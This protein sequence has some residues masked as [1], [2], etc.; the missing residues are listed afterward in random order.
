MTPRTE[1]HQSPKISDQLAIYNNDNDYLFETFIVVNILP[2]CNEKW[3][4]R[5]VPVHFVSNS[6]IVAPGPLKKTA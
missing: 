1:I 5:I 4:P 6:Y 2:L 3:F